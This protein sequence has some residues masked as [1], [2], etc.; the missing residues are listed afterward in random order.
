MGLRNEAVDRLLEPVIAATLEELTTA[1]HALDR[2]LR[3]EG[4]GAAVVQ[5]RPHR[6]LLRLLP[7]SRAASS[8][9]RRGFGGMMPR[10]HR[11]FARAAH[12]EGLRRHGSLYPREIVLIIPT[13]FGIMVINYLDQFVPG[14]PIEQ[15]I[16]NIEARATSLRGFP[17]GRPKRS[18]QTVSLVTWARGDCR[19][20]SSKSLNV[21]SVSISRPTFALPR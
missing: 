18:I 15:I 4:L 17:A 19:P 10:P 11:Q 2:V 6:R 5:E 12:A 13:L 16:A 14:G 3:A 9:V 8:S 1:T 20:S 7:L 21:S